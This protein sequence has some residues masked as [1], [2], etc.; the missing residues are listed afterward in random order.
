MRK[1]VARGVCRS[2]QAIV[3]IHRLEST[4][5]HGHQNGTV[6]QVKRLEAL[7]IT[8]T[9]GRGELAVDGFV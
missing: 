9:P 5:A 3:Q 2:Q 8:E 4:L 6:L 7:D 1:H